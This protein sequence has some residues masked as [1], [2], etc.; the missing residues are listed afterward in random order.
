M[1]RS[2]VTSVLPRVLLDC[3][4]P[5]GD[6]KEKMGDPIMRGGGT[7]RADRRI[8]PDRSRRSP[9]IYSTDFPSVLK[10]GI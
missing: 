5:I 2:V 4:T 7:V 8:R 9:D 1:H 3:R 6:G 10:V